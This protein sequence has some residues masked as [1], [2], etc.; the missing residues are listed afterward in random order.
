MKKIK[1]HWDIIII[2]FL[3]S[4]LIIILFTGF[5]ITEKN[6]QSVGFT[7]NSPIFVLA[8]NKSEKFIRLKYMGNFFKIDFYP[9]YNI[10]DN[11]SKF[12]CNFLNQ[13]KEN[14]FLLFFK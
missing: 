13:L 1:I 8:N 7:N 2:S 10:T 3:I 6:T 12:V 5:L 4:S 14:L 9:I 11:V